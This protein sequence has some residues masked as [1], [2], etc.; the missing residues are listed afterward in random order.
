M[1][2]PVGEDLELDVTFISRSAG[3]EFD[4]DLIGEGNGQPQGIIVGLL[5][6]HGALLDSPSRR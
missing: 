2:P 4:P 3:V 6:S 5:D 1:I